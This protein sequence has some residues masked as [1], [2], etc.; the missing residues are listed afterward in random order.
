MK[1]N[2]EQLERALRD[3]PSTKSILEIANFAGLACSLCGEEDD[4]TRRLAEEN[5]KF[6]ARD[7]HGF[8]LGPHLSRMWNKLVI[9]YRPGRKFRGVNALTYAKKRLE[10][11]GAK[12][13]RPKYN[14]GWTGANNV[15]V[16]FG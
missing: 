14:G 4:E 7:S 8:P 3:L 2:N 11:L 15:E 9:V 12:F 1:N 10:P 16:T 6:Q 13:A 5:R